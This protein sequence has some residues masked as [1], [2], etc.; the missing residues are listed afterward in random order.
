[1]QLG[2][3]AQG[4]S[5][6]APRSAAPAAASAAPQKSAPASAEEEIPTINLDDEREEIKI[7]DVP[8]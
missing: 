6:G 8:F 1:M 3:G 2:S 5:Q 4:T 7:E